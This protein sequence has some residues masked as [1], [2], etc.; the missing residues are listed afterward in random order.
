MLTSGS[1]L[2]LDLGTGYMAV[3]TSWESGYISELHTLLYVY[4][5]SI[6]YKT[7][8][9]VNLV[10]LKCFFS[11]ENCWWSTMSAHSSGAQW[12]HFLAY[13]PDLQNLR[14]Q[15]KVPKKKKWC[16]PHTF[17]TLWTKCSQF[18]FLKKILFIYSRETQEERGR[19]I[20]R[21]RSRLPA[22]A[23]FR[24]WWSWTPG[25][26]PESKADA[27]PL[28]HLGAPIFKF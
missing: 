28:S 9:N 16:D 11:S 23:W 5:N 7:N 10:G 3:F 14:Q 12:G 15:V 24:T 22:G 26:Q 20:G 13:T 25:S 8:K 4:Y 2:R 21:G 17:N 18:R 27:Q 19:D 6:K 1:V